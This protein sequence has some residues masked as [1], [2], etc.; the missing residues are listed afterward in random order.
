[1][2]LN[3]SDERTKALI[4]E[5]IVEMIKEKRDVFYEIIVEALEDVGLAQAITEGRKDKF[6]EEDKILKVTNIVG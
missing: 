6:V 1:M 4:A 2:T 3:S 5:V